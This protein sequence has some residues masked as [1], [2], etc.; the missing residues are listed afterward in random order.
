[1]NLCG[2]A[3]P[4]C[5]EQLVRSLTGKRSDKSPQRPVTLR[6]DL[7]VPVRASV[8]SMLLPPL[9]SMSSSFGHDTPAPC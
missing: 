9:A 5:L 2:V 1:M 8:R 4:L 3:R 6:V 7:V